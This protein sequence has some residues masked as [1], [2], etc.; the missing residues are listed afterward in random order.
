MLGKI[1]SIETFGTVDGPGI[2]FVLFLKGCPLRCLYCHNPDTWTN[3]GALQLDEK[4]IISRVLKYKNYYRN[5]GLTI[6]GGEP[7]VQ[8]DFLI[9]LCKLAKMNNI[10]TAIDTSGCTFNENDTNKFDELIKYVDLFLVDIKHINEEKCIKL[11]GKTNVNTLNFLTYL[12]KKSIKVWIRQVLL[13]GYTT[14]EEDLFQTR[15][16]IESLSNVE[17]IEVLPYHTMGE[18][19]YQNL[20]IKY[21]LKGIEPPSKELVNRAYKILKG[22]INE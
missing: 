13:P 1:H 8:I 20:N 10:H 12:D 19:K 3:D 7:L 5:G 11:T 2:R 6:S 15:K 14:D 17:K 16:F 22:E 4:E 9:E 18:V 21:P